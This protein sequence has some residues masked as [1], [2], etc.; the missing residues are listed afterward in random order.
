MDRINARVRKKIEN[1]NCTSYNWFW[2]GSWLGFD[3]CR[4]TL[5]VSNRPRL[6]SGPI[7]ATRDLIAHR[8]IIY[9]WG[10]NWSATIYLVHH[11]YTVHFNA[12]CFFLWIP[13]SRES[14]KG[15]QLL[16]IFLAFAL[17]FSFYLEIIIRFCIIFTIVVKEDKNIIREID[18]I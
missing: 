4:F 18:T 13:L 17:A 9:P 8:Y 6:I 7:N 11:M 2:R 16:I 5:A 14:V 15:V 12:V 1:S 10:A 3:E